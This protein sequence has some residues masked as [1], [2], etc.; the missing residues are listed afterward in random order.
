MTFGEF[1]KTRREAK[2][3]TQPE[4]SAQIG[5]E[6]SYLSKLE[7]NKA[8]P[9]PES[10]DKLMQAYEFDMAAIGRQVTDAELQKLKDIAQ[11]RDFIV[12]HK[13]RSERARRSWLLVGLL[14]LM[15]GSAL[16]AYGIV[17]KDARVSTYLYESKGLTKEGEPPYLFAEMPDYRTFT[18]FMKAK[19]LREELKQ[20]PLFPR[21]DFKQVYS[22]RYLGEYYDVGEEGQLRR[23]ALVRRDHTA[24]APVAFYMSISLGAMLLA[25]AMGAF[26]VSRRW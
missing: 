21:L 11:V 26:F 7:N 10:F 13:K 4:A 16:T 25:G 9:S 14:A 1:I 19:M 8:I 12:S 24:A 22:P 6:Q 5:I 2:N 17:I 20:N 18:E 3:W 23:F 15:V